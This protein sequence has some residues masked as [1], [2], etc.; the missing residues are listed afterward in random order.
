LKVKCDL[1]G[2]KRF[3]FEF[4]L[5]HYDTVVSAFVTGAKVNGVLHAKPFEPP[6]HSEL[7]KT[8]L[9]QMGSLTPDQ[10]PPAHF[11]GPK[12]NWM[13]G[14]GGGGGGGDIDTRHWATPFA[15]KKLVEVWGTPHVLVGLHSLPGV[16]L[17]TWIIPAV[18][19]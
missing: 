1:L 7:G 2:F 14:G 15:L 18:I 12:S 10:V 13:K 16:R 17:F 5:Y 8:A 6:P 9:L 11:K 19:N 3:A 4:N